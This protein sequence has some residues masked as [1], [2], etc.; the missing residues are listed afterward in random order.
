MRANWWASAEDPQFGLAISIGAE[1]A[2]TVSTR[3]SQSSQNQ[4]GISER[5]D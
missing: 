5:L 3:S 4:S 1:I 2:E